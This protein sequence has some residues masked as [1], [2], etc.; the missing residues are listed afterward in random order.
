MHLPVCQ[1]FLLQAAARLES[2][3]EIYYV[4]V[5]ESTMFLSEI[6]EGQGG[7]RDNYPKRHIRALIPPQLF[8]LEQLCGR[9][10]GAQQEN[11]YENIKFVLKSQ[12][13][14]VR[15]MLELQRP[16]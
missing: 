16:V 12:V 4:L 10:D 8:K 1:A 14:L 6:C 13:E 7:A 3:P 2:R 9:G 5:V 11:A 15:G